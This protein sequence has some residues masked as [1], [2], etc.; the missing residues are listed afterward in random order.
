MVRNRM[1]V[2]MISTDRGLLN[3]ESAV[4][5]RHR[6]YGALA[7]EL[8]IVLFALGSAHSATPIELA[9]NVH[10]YPTASGAKF[11]FVWDAYKIGRRLMQKV[12][13]NLI[14]AQNPFETGLVAWALAR[15]KVRVDFQLHTDPFSPHFYRSHPLNRWRLMLAKVLLPKGHAIRVVSARIARAVHGLLPNARVTVLPIFVDTKMI[16]AHAPAYD[17]HALYPQFKTIVLA[18]SRLEPEKN[19]ALGIEALARVAS[20]HPD[21]GLVIVGRGSQRHALERLARERGVGDRV[22]FHGWADETSSAF[23]TADIFMLMSDF[24]GYALTL[25]EAA[26]AGTP[27]VTTDVGL[28]GDILIDEESALVC[29]PGDAACM[30][31]QL[32]RL[33]G[34]EAL[35]KNLAEAARAAIEKR[36][37]QDKQEYLRAYGA[38]WRD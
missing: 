19:I 10:V 20:K 4:A 6:D 25:I 15:G 14:S 1:R 36:V 13:F 11:L 18:L 32:D 9:P 26:A 3:P 7:Q 22:V 5:L 21:L 37:L 17:L 2:L 33:A 34:D 29:Q 27:I 16:T 12:R 28:V 30:A 38:V 31:K 35:R 24:E 8:H 23:K